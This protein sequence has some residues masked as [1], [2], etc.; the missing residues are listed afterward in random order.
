[1]PITVNQSATYEVL[2]LNVI[3]WAKDRQIIPNAKP[4]TQ[5][6][7]GIS[8]AGEL[9]EA[10][11]DGFDEEE[12]G[13]LIADA[14]GDIAVCLINY[15]AVQGINTVY[16]VSKVYHAVINIVPSTVSHVVAEGSSIAEYID[17]ISKG[18]R[19]FGEL[20][21][22]PVEALMTLMVA[23]GNLSDAEAKRVDQDQMEFALGTVLI[24]LIEVSA[25]LERD[26]VHCLSLAYDEIKDRKG[27]LTPDGTFV[28][29]E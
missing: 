28:K 5:L 29:E 18:P 13:D 24:H 7:K 4:H 9:I 22:H 3:Q 6:L 16:C 10:V 27:Y 20:K 25:T 21:R 26:F 2:E 15:A 17:S 8:E 19:A 11:M 14:I 1:M 23:M 12:D